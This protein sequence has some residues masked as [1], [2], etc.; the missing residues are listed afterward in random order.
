[1]KRNIRFLFT[2]LLVAMLGLSLSSCS[3]D[4]D[5]DGGSGGGSKAV[6]VDGKAYNTKYAWWKAKYNTLTLKFCSFDVYDLD[7]IYSEPEQIRGQYMEMEIY[8]WE[9]SDVQPGTYT[10]EL[11]FYDATTK[12]YSIETHHWQSYQFYTYVEGKVNVTRTK[13]GD[14][15]SITIPETMIDSYDPNTEKRAGSVP[16]SFNYTGKISVMGSYPWDSE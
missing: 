1:M 11:I 7:F 12:G 13:D 2:T 6:V 16:F 3:K 14:N 8:K 15:F 4:D 9:Y 5:D 10:A